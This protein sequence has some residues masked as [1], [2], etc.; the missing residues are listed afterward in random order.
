[1]SLNQIDVPT[2]AADDSAD[3]DDSESSITSF[4]SSKEVTVSLNLEDYDDDDLEVNDLREGFSARENVNV[5]SI[6]YEGDKILVGLKEKQRLFLC[7]VFRLQVVKGGIIYNNVHYNASNEQFSIWHPL[8][9]SIPSIQS[10]YYAGWEETCHIE[11][12]RKELLMEELKDYPCVIRI[13]NGLV[14]GLEK[15]GNLSSDVRYLWAPRDNRRLS[16]SSKI[17]TYFFLQEGI[18]PFIPLHI[19]DEWTSNIERL[20]VAH[21]SSLFDTRMMVIGGK[22]SGKST[23]LRLLLEHFLYNGEKQNAA[24]DVLYLDLDPGQPE[25]SDPDCVSLNAVRRISKTLGRHIGQP[26]SK[27]YKQLYVGSNS[28]QDVP[29]LYLS[30][31]DEL[32][33]QL[34]KVDHMGT[35]LINL[36]GW[37][38]GYGLNIMNHI[39]QKYKPTHIVVLGSKGSGRHLSELDLDLSFKSYSRSEYSPVITRISGVSTNPEAL[40][41]QSPQIR[42]FKT[43]SYFHTIEKTEPGLKYDFSP[44]LDKPPVQISYGTAGI[45][46]INFPEEFSGLHEDDIKT[47]LEGTIVGLFACRQVEVKVLKHSF[48]IAEALPS[49]STFICLMLIHSIDMEKTLMN[50]YIPEFKLGGI[51]NN[52]QVEWVIVRGRSETPLCELFPINRSFGQERIPYISIEQRKKHE[53]VWKVRKNVMRRGHHMK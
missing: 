44:L 8:C 2:Y 21:K 10:S 28:P 49:D 43:L 34:E 31:V 26:Y 38:K 12:N 16:F 5:H 41:F 11:G 15:V 37:I 20:T 24:D 45:K 32:I 30:C 7:G 4:V 9:N 22:N 27:V 42:T 47:A 36:P 1:M 51:K 25:Y 17:C 40:R 39:I 23:F 33:D 3:S 35:S 19:S 52:T 6:G 13:Q 50:V 29:N 48:P 46:G 18:D 53:H 14:D